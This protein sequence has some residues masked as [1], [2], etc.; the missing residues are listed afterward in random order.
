MTPEAM[1][2][3]SMFRVVSKDGED[4]DFI[5]NDA[6]RLIDDNL[7]GSGISKDSYH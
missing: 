6:Q 5:L 7:T 2:I 1:I 3:E 4:L